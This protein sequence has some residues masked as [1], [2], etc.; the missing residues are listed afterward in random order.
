[1]PFG[2]RLEAIYTCLAWLL[3]ILLRV[4]VLVREAFNTVKTS[5]VSSIR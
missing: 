1:M 4:F 5:I 2:E 3:L